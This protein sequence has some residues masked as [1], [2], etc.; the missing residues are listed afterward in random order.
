MRP[1]GRLDQIDEV[2]ADGVVHAVVA[3][4]VRGV[5]VAVPVQDRHVTEG[6]SERRGV[7][8]R[9]RRVA[10]RADHEHLRR[11]RGRAR[12]ALDRRQ[13]VRRRRPARAPG[14]LRPTVDVMAGEVGAV[15]GHVGVQQVGERL[16]TTHVQ[17]V[18]GQG[19]E[20]RGVAVGGL[21]QPVGEVRPRRGG[22]EALRHDVA[23]R[24]QVERAL[25]RQPGRG[26]VAAV[27]LLLD[28]GEGTLGLSGDGAPRGVGALHHQAGLRPVEALAGVDRTTSI[29]SRSTLNS[30]AAGSTGPS[31]TSARTWSGNIWAYTAPSAV[32]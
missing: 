24:Q 27:E 9:R 31:S 10:D 5:A 29:G 13:G 16:P 8:E 30:P 2:P 23:E 3:L 18:I 15:D 20:E 26:H 11:Q 28:L 25:A 32:P 7:L 22:V 14:W 19:D 17:V 1:T 12:R 6:G 4:Q 21:V